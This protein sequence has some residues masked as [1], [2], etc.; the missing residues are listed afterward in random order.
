MDR[1]PNRAQGPVRSQKETLPETHEGPR[2][3]AAPALEV[4]GGLRALDV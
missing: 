2:V 1:T 4:G 3:S